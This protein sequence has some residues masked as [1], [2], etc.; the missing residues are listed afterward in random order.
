MAKRKSTLGTEP[1]L[2]KKLCKA[3]EK[4]GVKSFA[5]VGN[6][7]Q[8][9][10]QPDRTHHAKGLPGGTAKIEYKSE[11]GKISQLQRS[12]GNDLRKREVLC[13][14]YWFGS[15]KFTDFEENFIAAGSTDPKEWLHILKEIGRGKI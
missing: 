1:V 4:L 14:V 12:I 11:N 7:M 10:G 8:Q 6:K 3:L 5:V 15:E 13:L 9:A 2:T